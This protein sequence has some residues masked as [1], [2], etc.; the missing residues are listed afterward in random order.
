MLGDGSA[1]YSYDPAGNRT[2][3]GYAV[4]SN[5]HVSNDGTWTY[6]YDA[7]GNTASKSKGPGLE[8]WVYTFDNDNRLTNILKTSNGTT[9]VTSTTDGHALRIEVGC[10]SRSS[11]K[12]DMETT[13]RRIAAVADLAGAKAERA[14]DYPGWAPNATS[15]TRAGCA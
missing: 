4:G 1:S 6:T 7:E 11:S 3:S 5:N 13:L 15:P 10:L 14:N 9:T 2:M 12:S 8:G